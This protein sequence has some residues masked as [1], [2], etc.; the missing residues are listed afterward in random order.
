M[1]KI[2]KCF[3]GLKGTNEGHVSKFSRDIKDKRHHF[4]QAEKS[5]VE[6]RKKAKRELQ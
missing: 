1:W 6:V 4:V 5:R 2:F 3:Q